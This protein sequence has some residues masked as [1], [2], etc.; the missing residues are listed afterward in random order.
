MKSTFRQR[1]EKFF[2]APHRQKAPILNSLFAFLP[3]ELDR[4]LRELEY[5]F[6]HLYQSGK[7][8]SYSR[9][10]NILGNLTII[11]LIYG[12]TL[13][14]RGFPAFFLLCVSLLFNW[15]LSHW[16]RF[17]VKNAIIPIP[18]NIFHWL[19]TNYL[20][21]A[22]WITIL[23]LTLVIWFTPGL[24]E[25]TEAS[26]KI[27]RHALIPVIFILF[28]IVIPIAYTLTLILFPTFTDNERK[29]YSFY[30]LLRE[31][32]IVFDPI[33]PDVTWGATIRA[34]VNVPFVYPLYLIF[35]AAISIIFIKHDETMHL[36][37]I[38]FF[39]CMWLFLTFVGLHTRYASMLTLWKRSLFIRGQLIVS[40]III[41][42]ALGRL[43]NID[44][45]TT[46]I[47][48]IP[49]EVIFFYLLSLYTILWFYGYWL[50]HLLSERLLLIFGDKQK[51]HP[52]RLS[53]TIPGDITKKKN[54]QERQNRLL[55]I[56]GG[57][58][59]I[60]INP[61][62][63]GSSLCE[64]ITIYERLALFTKLIEKGGS[65]VEDKIEF[66]SITKKYNFY[67]SF[68]N[69]VV[70]AIFGFSVLFLFQLETKSE[71]IAQERISPTKT[72]NLVKLNSRLFVQNTEK[73]KP[74][75]LLSASGG[76][77]RAALFSASLLRG[78]HQHN[79]LKDIALVSGVSGG[80]TALAYFASHYRELNKNDDKHWERFSNVMARPFIQDV[81]E[82]ALE[83]RILTNI[84]LG[85]LLK[86]SFER[87]FHFQSNDIKLFKTLGDV[88]QHTNLGVILN[89]SLAGH[90]YYITQ[91]F[92][93]RHSKKQNSSAIFQGGRLVFTNLDGADE[94]FNPYSLES[95]PDIRFKYIVENT[96]STSLATA[97]ALN[98][99][100][101]PIFSNAAVDL[102]NKEGK[103][104]DR[105]WVTD[106]GAVDNRGA[107]SL[108]LALK[109]SLS[110]C[111]INNGK[112]IVPLD[113]IIADASAGS[114]DFSQNRGISTA[115]SASGSITN[116]LI[117]QLTDENRKL[118]T[119]CGGNKEDFHLY[120]LDMPEPLRIRGGMGTHWLMPGEITIHPV[121][122]PDKEIEK[123][124]AITLKGKDVKQ[125]IDYLHLPD[126]LLLKA[127]AS[128]NKKMQKAVEMVLDSHHQKVWRL[129]LQGNSR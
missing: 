27:Y 115:L 6:H 97:A 4:L 69:I 40:L 24:A 42:V 23:T 32:E 26:N 82:G 122:Y 109:S 47:E 51:Q 30:K 17:G 92:S 38:G 86:E 91:A 99:N 108:L 46:I 39:I 102:I 78:L 31:T 113:I 56:H 60:A 106:G 63:I 81:L 5:K 90:P 128:K 41:M 1:W 114:V 18:P 87:E 28:I 93:K 105:Y 20:L 44:Y 70:L 120:Y 21:A 53:Y 12:P 10:A 19:K 11:F 48:A 29:K 126:Q 74:I 103:G 2:Y 116:L 121:K 65:I 94:I 49:S 43:L 75:I 111:Q 52:W 107:I 16:F 96:P 124:E 127:K 83:W 89:T 9:L 112:T 7:G 95:A 58:R 3:E 36:V 34:L 80:G 84:R 22:Q 50:N 13:S 62:K 129:F 76:G 55:Q 101:P 85:T 72:L 35:P 59:F 125:I 57:T 100:F 79:R 110:N 117:A 33:S 14:W 118:Y 25:D 119:Q 8:N 64:N 77:T 61:D 66:G 67:F 98:A 54:K 68:M 73:Q 15:S 37:A 45:V 71:F 88:A 104:Y 123:D